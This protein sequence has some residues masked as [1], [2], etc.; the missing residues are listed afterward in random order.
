LRAKI[1]PMMGPDFI[2]RHAAHQLSKYIAATRGFLSIHIIIPPCYFV[3]PQNTLKQLESH[4][5]MPPYAT[6][7]ASRP[8]ATKHAVLP[9]SI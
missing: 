8:M 1:G 2:P 3:V 7:S 5:L 9:P 6:N 4:I